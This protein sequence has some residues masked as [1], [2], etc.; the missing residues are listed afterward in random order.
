M[1]RDLLIRKVGGGFGTRH[2][3]FFVSELLSLV[4]IPDCPGTVRVIPRVLAL[5][6]SPPSV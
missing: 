5:S 6:G 2:R 1:I 4:R 3:L